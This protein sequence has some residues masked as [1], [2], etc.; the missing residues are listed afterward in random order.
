MNLEILP[1]LS[2]VAKKRDQHFLDTQKCV[3]TIVWALGAA[4]SILIDP[5]K[6]SLDENI[7]TDYINHAG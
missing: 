6:D 2:D 1:L 7:F 3:G 5:P 4:V